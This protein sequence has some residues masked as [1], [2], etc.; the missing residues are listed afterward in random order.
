VN[1]SVMW[2]HTRVGLDFWEVDLLSSMWSLTS[3][4]VTVGLVPLAVRAGS[5]ALRSTPTEGSV[6]AGGRAKA[7][8]Y[9]AQ[10]RTRSDP[11]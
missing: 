1:T 4:E 5:S 2:V 9:E 11:S 6:D 3:E 7:P 10:S 8:S